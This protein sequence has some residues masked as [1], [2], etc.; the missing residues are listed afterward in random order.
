M[1]G[2]SLSTLCSWIAGPPPY[3]TISTLKVN[4]SDIHWYSPISSQ[5]FTN[6][7]TQFI[8]LHRMHTPNGCAR[9]AR[10]GKERWCLAVKSA[11]VESE[12]ILLQAFRCTKNLKVEQTRD[13]FSYKTV[14]DSPGRLQGQKVSDQ[15][16]RREALWWAWVHNLY[17]SSRL[18]IDI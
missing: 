1:F 9:T 2:G 16:I 4:V 13:W 14:I 18:Y 3:N 11:W 15:T 17:V 8:D 12:L 7:F 5:I 6:I 10:A